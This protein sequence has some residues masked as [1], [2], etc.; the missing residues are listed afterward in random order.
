MAKFTYD[1]VKSQVDPPKTEA[2]G[3]GLA[4]TKEKINYKNLGHMKQDDQLAA[5]RKAGYLK[6]G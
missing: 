4:P 2:P 3:N 1:T 5:L 6:R